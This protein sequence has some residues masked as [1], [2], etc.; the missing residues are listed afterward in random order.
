MSEIK[1][2][3]SSILDAFQKNAP[4]PFKVPI[5]EAR[6]NIITTFDHSA[7]IKEGQ[8]LPDFVLSDALG[9]SV[10]SKDLLSKGPILITFYRGSWCPF[11][12]VALRYLQT[13][14]DAF[15]SRGVTLVAISPELPDTSLTTA[16][17]LDLKFPVLSDVGNVF[18]GKLGIVWQ[19]PD[20]LRPVFERAGHNLPK[21]TGD[22]S[23]KV[24]VPTTLLVDGKGIVRNTF[25][26]P[27]YTQR[28]DPEVAL[29]WV[30][31]LK[32]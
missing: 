15:A 20:T 1:V 14:F 11:C 24:P 4:E 9:Q 25:I 21:R 12:N 23:Y 31:A 6:A 8:P 30:D 27:D 5:N 19:Q 18:A 17:K 29:G 32:N 2:E 22:D 7:T 10:S 16:E 28:L 26:D 13:H 3:L